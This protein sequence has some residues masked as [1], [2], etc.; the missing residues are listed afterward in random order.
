MCFESSK[1][2]DIK[3]WQSTSKIR[4]LK[5]SKTNISSFY[6]NILQ[7]MGGRNSSQIIFHFKATRKK[8]KG[9]LT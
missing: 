4:N 5:V 3:K 7:K 9:I 6:Q 8:S 1:L 2:H